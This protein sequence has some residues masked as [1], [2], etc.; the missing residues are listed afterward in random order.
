MKRKNSLSLPL[1]LLLALV[2][3][4]S[5]VQLSGCG[6]KED[7]TTAQDADT[8]VRIMLTA[9]PENEEADDLTWYREPEEVDG[10]LA[11]IYGLEN[12]KCLDGAVACMDGTRAFELAV[13]HVSEASVEAVTEAMQ[14][15]LT[16]RRGSF[17]GYFPDQ[18][19][20]VGSGLILTRGEWVALVVCEDPRTARDCFESCFGDGLNAKGIPAILG[21]DPEDYRPDGRLIYID[22]QTDDMTLFEDSAILSAWRSGDDS[23]L[24]SDDKKVLDAAAKVVKEWTAPDMSDYEKEQALY[25]WL[26]THVEYDKSHYREGGAP[27]TSYEPYGPLIKGKGVCLGYAETFRLLMDMAGV[28]CV[29]VTGASFQNR[30]NHAWNMVKLSGKWYCVDSTWDHI[31]GF[32]DD[33]IEELMPRYQYFNVTSQYLADTDHQWDYDNTP[34]ATAEDGGKP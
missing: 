34:E 7:D 21:P 20:M 25:V 5:L 2:L 23:D 22:P 29:T 13:L 9:L 8:I 3:L 10:Y 18:A 32:Q 33:A 30:E 4:L 17:T 12:I 27:R 15:Y 24:S 6:K 1:A 16:S 28:E 26:T 14:E 31:S 19:A 11:D